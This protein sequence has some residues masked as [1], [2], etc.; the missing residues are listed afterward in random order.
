MKTTVG[1]YVTKQTPGN[2]FSDVGI[3]I[4]GVVGSSRFGQRPTNSLAVWTLLLFEERYLL[5][6]RYTFEGIQRF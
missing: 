4:E 2:D 6:L 3:I 1:I 5:Q